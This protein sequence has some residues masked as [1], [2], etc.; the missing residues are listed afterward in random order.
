MTGDHWSFQNFQ[1]YKAGNISFQDIDVDAGQAMARG[2]GWK[3]GPEMT[4]CRFP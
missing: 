1:L 2:G 4:G 3:L